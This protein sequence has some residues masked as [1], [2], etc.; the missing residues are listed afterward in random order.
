MEM[1][2]IFNYMSEYG[3]LFIGLIIFLEYL[4]LPGFPA[5]IILPLGGLWAAKAEI[6]F[7]AAFMVSIL[8]ALVASWILYWIGLWGG[9]LVLKKYTDKF[10]KQKEF[11][12]KQLAYLKRRGVVGVFVGKLIPVARTIISIPAGT[13]KLNFW[14]Y[15][16]SSALGI[17]IWNGVLMASGYFFGAELMT[18]LV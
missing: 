10:P 1:M 12:D 2:Q 13:L 3:L 17:M 14:K 15:T 11:I 7:V 9:E 5:G 18:K 8:A 6:N 16:I 4:N